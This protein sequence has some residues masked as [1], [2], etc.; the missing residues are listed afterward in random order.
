MILYLFY[1]IYQRL[2][3]IVWYI[4]YITK[5]ESNTLA[6]FIIFLY[7]ANIK[8]NVKFFTLK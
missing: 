2:W 3:P 8:Y 4:K 5:N 1:K 7:R 6:L